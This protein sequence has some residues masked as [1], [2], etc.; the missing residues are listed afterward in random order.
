MVMVPKPNAP[1]SSEPQD[2]RGITL[3]QIS[4][5]V[6]M[7]MI[8]DRHV[9]SHKVLPYHFGFCRAH[10]TAM[11]SLVLRHVMTEYDRVGLQL[12]L[13]FQDQSKAYDSLDRALIEPLLEEA[14]FSE[15]AQA[16]LKILRDDEITVRVGGTRAGPNFKSTS[17]VRQGCILSPTIFIYALDMALRRAIRTG[18]LKGA[19]M[20]TEGGERIFVPI[21]A[22]AD[23]TVQIEESKGDLQ[24]AAV[25]FAS[26]IGEE[27]LAFNDLKSYYMQT[28]DSSGIAHDSEEGYLSRLRN[29]GISVDGALETCLVHCTNLF[30]YRVVVGFN[31]KPGRH[32]LRCPWSNCVYA[33]T[34]TECTRSHVLLQ[35]HLERVHVEQ[36][37]KWKAFPVSIE[38]SPGGE[39]DQ[40]MYRST[41]GVRVRAMK[42]L[43]P[44][45]APGGGVWRPTMAFK[46]LGDIATCDLDLGPTVAFRMTRGL[47]AFHTWKEALC[48]KGMTIATRMHMFSAYVMTV[49]LFNSETWPITEGLTKVMESWVVRRLRSVLHKWRRPPERGGFITARGT[50]TMEEAWRVGENDI[51][52]AR[53]REGGWMGAARDALEGGDAREDEELRRHGS[54]V[55]GIGSRNRDEKATDWD[56]SRCECHRCCKEKPKRRMPWGLECKRAVAHR[57]MMLWARYGDAR[58]RG[59]LPTHPVGEPEDRDRPPLK[60]IYVRALMRAGTFSNEEILDTANMPRMHDMLRARR[61]GLAGRILRAPQSEFAAKV[62]RARAEGHESLRRRGGLPMTWWE[63]VA[64]DMGEM[65]MEGKELPFWDSEA[66]RAATRPR[67]PHDAVPVGRRGHGGGRGRRKHAM[68]PGRKE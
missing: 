55:Q 7:R 64:K 52:A 59:G 33:A 65:T 34:P 66:L 24:D 20:V 22:F 8:L 21:L 10:S 11:N 51:A 28:V 3:L 36:R 19:R 56:I 39:E 30:G 47:G 9:G 4:L 67:R 58:R 48:S 37:R 15:S 46:Y 49:L 14:G 63:R 31:Y 35:K 44:L 53:E 16:I 27:Y 12:H 29:L 13:G 40:T 42:T 57:A 43:E 32:K 23:D 17:G 38:P 60:P 54:A 25:V 2:Q 50:L 26:E 68:T 45:K 5:K 1:A 6:M 61:L 41:R 62:L 18:K